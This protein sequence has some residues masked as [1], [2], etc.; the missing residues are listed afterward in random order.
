[1]ESIDEDTYEKITALSEQANVSLDKNRPNDAE[2]SLREALRL[3]PQ[4]VHQW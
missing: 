4:P 3:L 2:G 1:M